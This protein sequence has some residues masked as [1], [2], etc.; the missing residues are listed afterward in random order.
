MRTV[1]VIEPSWEGRYLML[2][3]LEGWYAVAVYSARRQVPVLFSE[4]FYEVH[5]EIQYRS[6][7]AAAEY[8]PE[9]EYIYVGPKFGKVVREFGAEYDEGARSWYVPDD[10]HNLVGTALDKWRNPERLEFLRK[11]LE[12]EHNR[13]CRTAPAGRIYLKVPLADKEQVQYRGAVYD[14][15]KKAWYIDR[16]SP[17]VRF[18]QWLPHDVEVDFTPEALLIPDDH[19]TMPLWL[20]IEFE[21]QAAA[22]MKGAVQWQDNGLWFAPVGA[23]PVHF[24]QWAMP[25]RRLGPK[26][27]FIRFLKDQG[28]DEDRNALEVIADGEPHAF[29]VLED[30]KAPS[31]KYGFFMK[32]NEIPAGWASNALVNSY[33][34]WA[35]PHRGLEWEKLL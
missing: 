17:S 19:L 7:L 21:D 18:A 16:R 33:Q 5:E 9:R 26:S 14:A 3:E 12:E 15:G 8:L 13:L 28:F 4:D 10:L 23:N 34:S 11:V 30:E 24:E 22:K 35:Y 20:F 2:R 29:F 1:A 32:P 25:P 31:G 6:G 27:A